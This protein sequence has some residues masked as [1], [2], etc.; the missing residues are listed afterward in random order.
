M[1]QQ[2]ARALD[3]RREAHD[4]EVTLGMTAE[5]HTAH[6]RTGNPRL[7]LILGLS[8]MFV[9][10]VSLG[11]AIQHGHAMDRLVAA[12]SWPFLMYTTANRDSQGHERISLTLM[13]QGVGPARIET[14]EAWWQNQPVTSALD[15]LTRCCGLDSDTGDRA[16]P[17]PHGT[18]SLGAVAPLV[19]RPGDSQTFLTLDRSEANAEIWQRLNAA[20]I[21]I[22]MRACYCS[23]FDECW[24]SDL[25]HTNAQRAKSCPAV[26]V[27]F[28]VPANWSQ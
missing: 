6:H 19:L 20:R 22:K 3:P 4:A 5:H 2:N 18:V 13:N 25:Q 12:N 1:H 24:V 10:V 27:P 16:A 17:M 7:D 26:K 14:F 21:Q 11:V 28:E 8:A 23:V 9:S 15:L